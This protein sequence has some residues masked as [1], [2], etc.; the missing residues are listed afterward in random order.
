MQQSMDDDCSTT[1]AEARV[2]GCVVFLS[3]T[4][5]IREEGIQGTLIENPSGHGGSPAVWFWIVPSISVSD[6]L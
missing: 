1:S 2:D 5:A 4:N 3:F 6:D